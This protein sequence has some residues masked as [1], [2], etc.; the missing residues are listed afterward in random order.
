[1][2]TGVH[3][4]VQQDYTNYSKIMSHYFV[5][6]IKNKISVSDA[7]IGATAAIQSAQQ[8]VVTR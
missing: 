6:A 1:M 4:P 7:L 3:R 8:S 2:L 5:Q